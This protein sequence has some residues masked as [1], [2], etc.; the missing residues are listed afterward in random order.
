MF[1]EENAGVNYVALHFMKT[2]GYVAKLPLSQQRKKGP[3]RVVQCFIIAALR[4][5]GVFA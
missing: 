2:L 4:S 3:F 5:R 1:T